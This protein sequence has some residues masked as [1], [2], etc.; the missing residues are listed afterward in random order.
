MTW[1]HSP[2]SQAACRQESDH[3]TGHRNACIGKA[4]H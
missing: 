3:A 1:T 2:K 4:A